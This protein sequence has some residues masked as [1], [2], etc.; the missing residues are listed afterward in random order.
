VR[1]Y[2]VTDPATPLQVLDFAAAGGTV[3]VGDHGSTPAE[4]LLLTDGQIQGPLALVPAKSLNDPPGG[5]D[6]LLITHPDFATA[7]APLAAQRAAQGL[8]VVIVDVEAIY[9]QFGDGRMDPTAIKAFLSHAYANW[10]GD[11]PQYV[12]LVGDGTSDPRGYRPDSRPTYLPPYLADVDPWLG[13]VASDNRYADL[14]D[15][16]LP[17]LRLGRLP[18]NTLTEV[19]A[20]VDKIISYEN[21]PLPGD[22]NARLVFGADNPSSAGDHH[23]DADSEFNTYATAAYGYQGT[24]VYLSETI[25]QAH[26]YVSAT[27]A[28]E[29]LIA[30]LNRGALLYTYFG[31]ASW[32][33]EA[34]LETDDYAPL[35]HQDHIT[36]LNNL[37]RWPV[38]L[39]MT[40]FTGRFTHPSSDTLDESLLR[41]DGAGA[42]A[43]WGASGA[44][45]VT[46]HRMLHR[47]F[48]QAVFDGGQRELGAATHAAFGNLYATG[49]HYDLIETY[50]LFGDPAL[51][52]NLTVVDWP[53]S[54]YLPLI[55]RRW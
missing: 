34:V 16:L 23:A 22:W 26:L 3:S 24:R 15:D 13:E 25:N 27:Q 31:H 12:L 38:V 41:A 29:A 37:R 14:T 53:F 36:R 2:D 1:V 50:H 20:I 10:P 35:F 8:R 44:G 52:L 30:A 11:A 55:A 21:N 43:V 18:V 33:Q 45:I 42:V 4:Y 5:A 17:D 6:Y 28:Q 7:L 47:S 39:H 54:S 48:Y 32:H 19:E 46:G 49:L 51:S 40:C 9:D